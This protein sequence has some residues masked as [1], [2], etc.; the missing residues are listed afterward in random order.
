MRG[1]S[2]PPPPPPP[3]VR[4]RARVVLSVVAKALVSVKGERMSDLV[5]GGL[6]AC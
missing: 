4:R 6:S 3:P 2:S 5:F 1:G